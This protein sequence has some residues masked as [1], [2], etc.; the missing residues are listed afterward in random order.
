[1]FRGRHRTGYL[2]GAH[3][4]PLQE[5]DVKQEGSLEDRKTKYY[6][7]GSNVPRGKGAL[8]GQTGKSLEDLAKKSGSDEDDRGQ[9]S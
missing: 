7:K 4:Q 5:E 6:K 1:L 9:M 2:G 3:E 8:E